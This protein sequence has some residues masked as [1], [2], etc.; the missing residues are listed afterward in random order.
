V[1][2]KI[3]E[4]LPAEIARELNGLGHDTDTSVDEGG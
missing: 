3:D 1:R 2:I 4:N